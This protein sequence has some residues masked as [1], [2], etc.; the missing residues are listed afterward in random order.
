MPSLA[1]VVL[2]GA[3][4]SPLSK[5][6]YREVSDLLHPFHPHVKLDPIWFKTTGDIDLQTSLRTL[7]K[8]DFFTKE[9]DA[10]LLRGECRIAIH[11]AKDLPDP[12]PQGLKMIA[13][14][15]GVDPRDALVMR[16]GESLHSLPA[17][18]K[19][20]TSSDRREVMVRELRADLIFI[21]IRGTIDQRLMKLDMGEADGVVVAEAALIR[22]GLTS[23]NRLLLAG[24]T[25]AGQGRLA[26]LAREE[27]AEM[28]RLFE[29]LNDLKTIL[30]LGLDLPLKPLPG[31]IIHYP[32]IRIIPRPL[33]SIKHAFNLISECTHLLFTSKTAVRLTCDHVPL[34]SLQSKQIFA[35]GEATAHELSRYSLSAS[36]IAKTETAEGV[37][38]LLKEE[39]Q[40]DICYFWPHS[41]KS[42][43][44][45]R[46]FFKENGLRFVECELYDTEVNDQDPLPDLGNVD[47]IFFT[48]PSTVEAFIKLFG[49]LP[50]NKVLS[51]IGPITQAS[52]DN[53]QLL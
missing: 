52:I 31:N 14:T 41:S 17:G 13:L 18:A 43:P 48:S 30:Y 50:R 27:D 22:L 4:A 2:A 16:P 21:D 40:S 12:L 25:V 24:E 42:R 37:I 39:T 20:A 26:V 5:A 8:T 10:A 36:K 34:A 28:G 33:H 9:I 45:I 32:I 23:L 49:I 35:I 7:D 6:Q 47:E 15:R 51:A 29:C 1:E 19:I 38:D 46:N 44:V 11:S 53:L 3:R